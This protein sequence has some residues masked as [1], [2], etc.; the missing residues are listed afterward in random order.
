MIFFIAAAKLANATQRNNN[1][2]NQAL[3]TDITTNNSIKYK[4]KHKHHNHHH[5]NKKRP[6]KSPI[7]HPTG[8]SLKSTA[9]NGSGGDNFSTDDADETI[10]SKTP[11]SPKTTNENKRPPKGE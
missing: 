2:N 7:L 3:S 6:F 11:L 8:S 10:N 9:S 5:H 4:H 1:N